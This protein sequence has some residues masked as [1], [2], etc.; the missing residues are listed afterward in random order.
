MKSQF[1][2]LQIIDLISPKIRSYGSA[3]L[4]S[5]GER[6]LSSFVFS[7]TNIRTLVSG[8]SNKMTLLG[9]RIF[10]VYG[11]EANILLGFLPSN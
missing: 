1:P 4:T 2:F 3:S 6:N 10:L 9:G 7:E 8:H 5:I 11:F